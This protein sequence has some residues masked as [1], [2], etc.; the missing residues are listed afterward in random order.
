MTQQRLKPVVKWVGGKRQL[1]PVLNERL[2]KEY[3]LYCEPFIGGGALLFDIQPQEAVINDL[4]PELINLYQVIKN[5]VES[6]IEDLQKHINTSEYF[7]NIRA[8]DRDAEAWQKLTPVERASRFIYLNKTCYNGLY[9]VNSQGQLNTP[10][11]NYKNP[12]ICD[13]ENLLAISNYFN[14]ASITMLCGDYKNAV[15]QLETNDFVY[16]DS[17]YH[18]VSSTASYTGYTASGFS[19]QNQIELYETCKELDSKG[20]MF[21]LS[22]SGTPFIKELYKDF[23]VEI[24]KAKRA[25][26]CKGDKRAAVEEVLVRNY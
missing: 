23:E 1:L 22:N 12:S 16:F 15:K 21:M 20:V 4:N 14:K 8:L 25:I 3:G 6:L 17:P 26:N 13:T 18:P 9:R 19:E 10:F 7:Y 11:G 5:E 2:P 24:V